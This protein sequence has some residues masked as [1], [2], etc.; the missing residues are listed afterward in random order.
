MLVPEAFLYVG[1]S[2]RGSLLWRGLYTVQSATIL[3]QG[4]LR[5]CC[6]Q[7]RVFRNICV[8]PVDCGAQFH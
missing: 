7:A 4:S 2:W 8:E 1:Q 5:A 3:R 6:I